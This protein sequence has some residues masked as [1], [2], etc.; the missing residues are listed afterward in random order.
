[1]KKKNKRIWIM[2]LSILSFYHFDLVFAQ[3]INQRSS[4]DILITPEA[5]YY[6]V[7]RMKLADARSRNALT[8]EQI[9]YLGENGFDTKHYYDQ[10]KRLRLV[11]D[12]SSAGLLTCGVSGV[13]LLAWTDRDD[14]GQI[15]YKTDRLV[16]GGTCLGVFVSGIVGLGLYL[17]NR[18]E[19]LYDEA[20]KACIRIGQ[21]ESGVGLSFGF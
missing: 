19:E 17:S 5:L 13:L 4:E 1:M 3:Y 8:E 21:T 16:A 20:E 14:K 6:D 12:I 9:F 7:S 10:C 15:V 2:L 11:R 18:A